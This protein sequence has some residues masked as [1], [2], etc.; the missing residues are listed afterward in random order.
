MKRKDFIRYSLWGAG[1]MFL[2]PAFAQL[3]NASKKIYP[4]TFKGKVIIIGAGA[5]GLYAAYLLNEQGVDVA[6]L[7]ASDMYGGRI[8]SLKDFSDFPVEL[9][10]EGVHGKRSAFYELVKNSKVP[11]VTNKGEDYYSLDG[12]LNTES[13]LEED[14]DFK[15]VLA[16]TETYADYSGPDMTAEQFAMQHGLSPRV[17]HIYNALVGNKHGTSVGRLSMAGLKDLE[18]RW[19]AGSDNFLLNGR[20]ILSVF[21]EKCSS[22]LPKIKLS[23]PVTG[24]DHT[25][26][27]ITVTDKNGGTYTADKIIITVPITILKS[28]DIK[29]TPALPV[30]KTAAFSKIGMGAGMK[31][32]LK[33]SKKFW[34]DDTASIYGPGY[35]SEFY[36]SGSGRSTY[37][38][39]LTA[40]TNGE[41]AEH[42]SF[43]D[44]EAVKIAVKEIDKIF[45]STAASRTLIDSYIMDWFKQP[46]IRGAYSYP[47][48][49]SLNARSTAALPV[50]N[51]LYFAGEAMHEGHFA[52]VHGAMETAQTTV[53]AILKG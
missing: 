49:G 1:G 17:A 41:N 48:L 13:Q 5:A 45:G 8:R 14:E 39:V 2:S 42:L 6:I 30:D 50:D 16:L 35:V 23:T 7:E 25:G 53:D 3:I 52:T 27:T 19:I 29:F 33:F 11:F 47:T 26:T 40:F 34:K 15:Q 12:F 44:K 46:Y 43:E 51:K 24:I 10:A 4:D 22:I 37:N 31:I 9:G 36:P 28:N 32:I 20:S 38:N 18:K 21:E